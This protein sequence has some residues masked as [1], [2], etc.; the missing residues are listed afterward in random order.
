M[1]I[2]HA[3][4]TSS[5]TRMAQGYRIVA[6]SAGLT[7]DEKKQITTASP[8][9]SA[10]C[11]VNNENVGLSF[12]PLQS[13]RYC[14]ARTTHAGLEQTARGGKRVLTHSFVLTADQFLTFDNNPFT[15]LNALDAGNAFEFDELPKGLLEPIELVDVAPTTTPNNTIAANPATSILLANAFAT[16]SLIAAGVENIADLLEAALTFLP[17][18]LRTEYS[19]TIGLK[20]ALARRYRLHAI[21]E[22]DLATKRVVR[23][24]PIQ[25]VED[26]LENAPELPSNAWVDLW[27]DC[28]RTNTLTGL[29]SLANEGFDNTDDHTLSEVATYQKAI[30]HITEEPLMSLLAAWQ[31]ITDEELPETDIERTMLDR[32]MTAKKMQTINAIGNADENTLKKCWQWLVR[33]AESDDNLRQ[34]CESASEKFDELLCPWLAENQSADV[35]ASLHESSLPF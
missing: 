22:A 29:A 23:G 12:Y 3:I 17:K 28:V 33:L 20:F 10:M 18:R 5:A 7:S 24:Q 21:A 11:P 2:D 15:V 32:Y 26:L 1:Q 35:D 14:I 31:P 34:A 9:H 19:F 30:N 8:S 25:L 4:F 16:D 13:G 6:S 27:S